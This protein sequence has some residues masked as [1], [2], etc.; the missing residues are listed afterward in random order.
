V[1]EKCPIQVRAVGSTGMPWRAS[2]EGDD[3]GLGRG[4][5]NPRDPEHVNVI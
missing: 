3:G 2:L 1:P 5:L 4:R